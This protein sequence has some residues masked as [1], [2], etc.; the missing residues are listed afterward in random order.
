MGETFVGFRG[1]EGRMGRRVHERPGASVFPRTLQ[2]LDKMFPLLTI[3][4]SSIFFLFH[5]FLLLVYLILS[6]A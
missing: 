5:V 4:T 3:F 6:W 2:A 1:W